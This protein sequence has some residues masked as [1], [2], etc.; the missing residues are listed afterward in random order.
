MKA[1]RWSSALL[2]AVALAVPPAVL[3]Q[4][5]ATAP[6]VT[7]SPEEMRTFLTEAEIVKTRRI[8]KGVTA[9][10]VATLSDGGVTHDAQV[11]DVDIARNIFEAGGKSEINFRDSYKY[12]VA[13]YEL[14]RLIGMTNVPMS[15]NRQVR[16]DPAAVTWWLDDVLM[17]EKERVNKKHKS[18]NPVAFSQQ[19]Q[20]MN[21]FDELIQNVDRNQEN[22]IYDSNWGMWLIDHTRAFRLGHDLK[23]P[24]KL[25]WCDRGLLQGMRNLTAEALRE[26]VGRNLTDRELDAVMARLDLI[27]QHYD[28]LIA[29]RGEGAVMFGFVPRPN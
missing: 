12:N 3:A 22:I 28:A 29:E 8:G 7:L 11:Q 18:P 5:A 6:A 26:A 21:I 10:D 13:A 25:A 9:S 17:D 19:T 2:L 20:T 4:E 23:D 14:A 16:G 24:K 1:P 15:V 27:V